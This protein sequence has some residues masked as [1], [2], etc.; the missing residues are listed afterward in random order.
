MEAGRPII[1]RFLLAITAVIATAAHPVVADGAS[2][3]LE[4]CRRPDPVEIRRTRLRKVLET[5]RDRWRSLALHGYTIEQ[6]GF[7]PGHHLGFSRVT[8]RDDRVVRVV[9]TGTG[10]EI[11]R[12]VWPFY[13]AATIDEWFERIDDWIVERPVGLRVDYHPTSGIPVDIELAD[14]GGFRRLRLV[15]APVENSRP[16]VFRTRIAKPLEVPP[17]G[18]THDWLLCEWE[19]NLRKWG[20]LGLTDYTLLVKGDV[21]T[22]H[23][24]GPYRVKIEDGNVVDVANEGADGNLRWLDLWLRPERFDTVEGWFEKLH[25]LMGAELVE[26][27]ISY[28]PET[29]M[30]VF[31]KW[32]VCE[33]CERAGGWFYIKLIEPENVCARR[34]GP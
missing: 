28:D 15:G 30:P 21:S 10:R 32:N 19:D 18:R 11:E 27:G 22:E 12:E 33:D 1:A 34:E 4:G 24:S 25:D 6:S 26:L 7:R 17:V 8:V 16:A 31:V 23:G 14:E 2:S 20:G 29:G 5:H 13:D 9:S 3:G